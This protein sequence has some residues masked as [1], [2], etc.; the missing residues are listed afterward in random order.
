MKLRKEIFPHQRQEQ[1]VDS[2]EN[3]HSF[4][5]SLLDQLLISIKQIFGNHR[6]FWLRLPREICRSDEHSSSLENNSCW[7]G[8]SLSQDHKSRHFLYLGKM[9]RPFRYFF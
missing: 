2:N 1:E 6:S 4:S 5:L 3:R 8:N 9:I 7:T